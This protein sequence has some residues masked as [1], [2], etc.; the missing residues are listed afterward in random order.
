MR[1]LH[2]RRPA[3]A[4]PRAQRRAPPAVCMLG[5]PSNIYERGLG[6]MPVTYSA[7]ASSGRALECG[8]KHSAATAPLRKQPAHDSCQQRAHPLCRARRS[9]G[10]L[11]WELASGEVP[12]RGTLRELRCARSPGRPSRAVHVT[13]A[14][15]VARTSAQQG[16]AWRSA[17]AL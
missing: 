2:A 16:P 14:S 5:C 4:L 8:W 9:F 15:V 1:M 3:C 7:A 12:R 6:K 11:L 10:V 13:T 17:S